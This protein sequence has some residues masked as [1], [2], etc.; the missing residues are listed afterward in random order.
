MRNSTLLIKVGKTSCIIGTLS[1]LYPPD[2]AQT[3]PLNEIKALDCQYIVT[4]L[5]WGRIPHRAM[6]EIFIT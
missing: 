4:Q 2:V 1:L 6:L 3:T 5:G